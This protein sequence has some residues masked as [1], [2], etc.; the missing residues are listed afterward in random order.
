MAKGRVI[1]YVIIYYTADKKSRQIIRP[2]FIGEN[3]F[4]QTWGQLVEAV[5][6]GR[7]HHYEVC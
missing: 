6:G 5:T 2:S 1:N 3:K 4:N 7:Y